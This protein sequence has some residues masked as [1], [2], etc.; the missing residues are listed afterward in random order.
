[1][2]S[3]AKLKQPQGKFNINLNYRRNRNPNSPAITGKISTPED[4]DNLFDFAA[5]ENT[6]KTGQSYWIGSVDMTR[7]VRQGLNTTK[8]NGT[9]FVAIRENGFKIFKELP[10][11]TPNPAYAALDQAKQEKEDSKPAY[12]ATWTRNAT[13][14]PLR[15][16]AWE[17]KPT[18]YGPWASGTTQY[19]LTKDQVDGLAYDMHPDASRADDFVDQAQPE[20]QPELPA[21]PVAK[22]RKRGD[23]DR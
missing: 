6:D 20:L 10:D 16:A 3:Q 9:H 5:F 11:G 4:P 7:S 8:T 2:D 13:D 18:R 14:K 22:S 19:P 23:R 21:E 1:M 15:A 12:W 17:R